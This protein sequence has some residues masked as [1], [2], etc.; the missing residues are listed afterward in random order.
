MGRSKQA[1]RRA[2]TMAEARRSNT[3]FTSVD[4]WERWKLVQRYQFRNGFTDSRGIHE[5]SLLVQHKLF[6]QF[7]ASL[8]ALDQQCANRSE[9]E[10]GAHHAVG[11]PRSCRVFT[12]DGDGGG[13]PTVGIRPTVSI[14]IRATLDVP[15]GRTRLFRTIVSERTQRQVAE[16]ILVG[17]FPLKRLSGEGV[18]RTEWM[19]GPS[20]GGVGPT[21]PICVPASEAVEKGGPA[22]FRTGIAL[23]AGQSVTVT[24]AV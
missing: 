15:F 8:R 9:K 3:V 24:I 4:E 5:F 22:C 11:E 21:V 19:S 23:M 10:A 18:S 16:S 12:H 6:K 2:S 7:T 14:S 1:M 20:L 17:V 13:E